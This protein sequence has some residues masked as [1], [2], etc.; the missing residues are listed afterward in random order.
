MR[1]IRK[2]AKGVTLIT[3][4]VMAAWLVFCAIAIIEL[5]AW[6][7]SWL[8][9]QICMVCVGLA[10]LIMFGVANGMFEE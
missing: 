4:N 2:Y 5:P 9:V 3:I 6:D 8:P 10:W 1:K 7:I